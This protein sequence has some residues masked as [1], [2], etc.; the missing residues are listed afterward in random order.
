MTKPKKNENNF[1]ILT[2]TLLLF[3]LHFQFSYADEVKCKKFDIK[4]KTSKFV[5]ETKKFQKKGLDDGK[6]QLNK[7]KN[8]LKEILPKK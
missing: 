8:K 5:E 2:F 6:K 4:C 3:N 1:I 7:T